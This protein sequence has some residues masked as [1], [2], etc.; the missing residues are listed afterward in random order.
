VIDRPA[1]SRAWWWG[2][3]ALAGVLLVARVVWLVFFSDL[4]LSED[5][6]HYWEWSRRLDWSYYSKGPGIAWLIGASTRL[7]GD[8]EWAL[9]APAAAMAALTMLGAGAGARWAFPGR[10]GLPL[11]AAALAACAPGVGVSSVL[12]T[13]DAP[14]MACWAWGGAFAALAVLRGRAWAWPALGAAVATGFLFK[15]TM[16]LL[17]LGVVGGMLATRD[18]PRVD[19][20]AALA[21]ACVGALGLVPVLVWNARHG[22]A[23]VRHLLGHLGLPGGDQPAPGAGAW[24][25]AWPLEYL[26]L[27]PV[28][29]GGVLLLAAIAGLRANQR[30]DESPRPDAST[31]ACAVRFFVAMSLPPLLFYLVV[32]L[33]VRTEANWAVAAAPT[34]AVPAAWAVADAGRRRLRWTRVLW[35][36]TLA[37]GLL[38]TIAPARLE[39]MSQ[40]RV[41]GRFIPV[42]RVTGMR[43]HAQAAVEQLD[44]IR[45][46][47]GLEPFVMTDH[48]GRAALLAFYLPGRPDVLNASSLLGGRRSQHD[49]WAPTSPGDPATARALRGRPALLLGRTGRDWLGSF[50]SVRAIGPLGGE[51]KPDS[52][53]AWVGIGYRG[54]PNPGGTDGK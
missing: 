18:R 9:R 23:T 20:R 44:A 6:A 34:L 41:Y 4:T 19:R 46:E 14:L 49:L 7:F 37:S 1:R 24:T 29:F 53:T 27:L 21:A 11:V 48:Y 42:E 12:M 13:I 52:R 8:S 2:P 10:P 38:V 33:A 40:R 16:L 47:T 5:E 54:F 22:W 51:P 45:V 28:V 50:E 32:S 3:L 35:W 17:P 15:Y 31:E 26:A 25:P 30:G 43:E 39:A 36:L